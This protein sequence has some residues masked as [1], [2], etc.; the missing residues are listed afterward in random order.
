MLPDIG[1]EI[2]DAQ[3]PARPS[4]RMGKRHNIAEQRPVFLCRRTLLARRLREIM[5]IKER[6]ARIEQAQRPLRRRIPRVRIERHGILR[7]PQEARAP[8]RKIEHLFRHGR[9]HG[10][11][12][13][14]RQEQ[15]RSAP[16]P[17]HQMNPC[18]QKDRIGVIRA[19]PRTI[20]PCRERIFRRATLN[21]ER[22]QKPRRFRRFIRT[23]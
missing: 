13:Q 2:A 12:H 21:R 11:P 20:L 5:P 7:M 15:Q 23:E 3:P 16:L 8:A 19:M 1:R 6:I 14:R 9:G 10:T 4:R 17:L 22:G 18:P